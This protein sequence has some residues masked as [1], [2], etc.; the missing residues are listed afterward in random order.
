MKR[1]IIAAALFALTAPARA[2]EPCPTA[3]MKTLA[4]FNRTSP[5]YELAEC[6][7]SIY[8]ASIDAAG[9]VILTT[10]RTDSRP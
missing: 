10:W 4:D 1:T 3:L 9:R 2:N 6:R 8:Q 7:Y 5:E